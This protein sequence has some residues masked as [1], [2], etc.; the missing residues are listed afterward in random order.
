MRLIL[1]RLAE[2]MAARKMRNLTQLSRR[3]G[4]ARNTLAALWYGRA[5]GVNFP[6]LD[7][8]CKALD[9]QPGDLLVY[10]PDEEDEGKET[11][12]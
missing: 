6:T 7:A 5:K 10:M 12:R 3:T 11:Q 9:C 1:T 8:L 2:V 4:L